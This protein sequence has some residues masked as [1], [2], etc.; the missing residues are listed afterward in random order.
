MVTWSHTYVWVLPL[1]AILSQRANSKTKNPRQYQCAFS[2]HLQKNN[3]LKHNLTFTT[4]TPTRNA[5][6]LRT[7]RYATNIFFHICQRSQPILDHRKQWKQQQVCK[8]QSVRLPGT[9]V[10]V[11]WPRDKPILKEAWHPAYTPTLQLVALS[12]IFR[13]RLFISPAIL[14]RV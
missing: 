2:I 4:L 8:H 11:H 10:T 12:S 13:S 6:L 14:A 3:N 1:V 9:T 5:P 7:G